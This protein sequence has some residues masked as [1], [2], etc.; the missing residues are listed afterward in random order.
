MKNN[1][2]LIRKTIHRWRQKF[3]VE[4]WWRKTWVPVDGHQCLV[5]R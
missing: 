1:V 5:K 2:F 4:E 3:H